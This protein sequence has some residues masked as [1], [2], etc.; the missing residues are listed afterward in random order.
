MP[1]RLIDKLNAH[2]SLLD[3]V[4]AEGIPVYT[5]FHADLLNLRLGEWERIG[6]RGAWVYLKG[7]APLNAAYVLEL[8][9]GES[10]RPQ[11]YVLDEMIVALDGHGYT[12]TGTIRGPRSEW[13]GVSGPPSRYPLT[14]TTFTMRNQGLGS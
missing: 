13:I 6:A 3:F 5:D 2:D 8:S 10:T 11:H 1:I 7:A 4:N 9:A 12:E 14:V